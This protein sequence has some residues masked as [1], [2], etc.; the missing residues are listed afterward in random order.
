MLNRTPDSKKTT[1]TQ[2]RADEEVKAERRKQFLGRPPVP[3]EIRKARE[4]RKAAYKASSDPNNIINQLAKQFG[5]TPDEVMRVGLSESQPNTAQGKAAS[6]EVGDK[7]SDPFK[8]KNPW[9]VE[10][11]NGEL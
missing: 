2:E 9:I 10:E 3:E 7:V 5:T 1:I 4:Q 11:K 8:P 6:L